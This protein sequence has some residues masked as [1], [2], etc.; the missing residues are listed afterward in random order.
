[1]DK[2]ISTNIAYEHPM[3][4]RIR[5]LLR[6][7]HFYNIIENSLQ[8]D[9]EQNCRLILE[10]LLNISD[11]LIRSD[12]KN[13][14]IKELKR[15]QDIFNILKNNNDVDAERL[16]IISNIISERLK[17]LQDQSYNPGEIIKNN[18]LVRIFSQRIRIPGGTCNFDLPR[19]HHWFRQSEFKRRQDLID[20]SSDLMPIKES[21]YII[22]EN[23]RRS[24]HPT[25]ESA[26]SGFY[27]KQ[28]G[29]NVPCQLIQVIMNSTSPYYPDISGVKHRFTI[30]FMEGLNSNLKQMQTDSVVEFQLHCCIL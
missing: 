9:S 20:W 29:A 14:I 1:M 15:Q 4:E 30:R 17:S 23:I 28:I 11:L 6:I 26:E 18:E 5:S 2:E 12:I 22:L 3:N 24:I 7:E 27:H 16:N 25:Y 21:A 8:E 19:L 10:A 13:E